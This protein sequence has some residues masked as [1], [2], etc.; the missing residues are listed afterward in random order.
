MAALMVNELKQ[1]DHLNLFSEALNNPPRDIAQIL[2]DILKHFG[3]THTIQEI[4]DLNNLLAWVLY[5]RR[6]LTLAE[7]NAAAGLESDHG[8]FLNIRDKI[9]SEFSAYFS[10][11]DIG[12]KPSN[13]N[14]KDITLDTLMNADQKDERLQA[15]Q[16]PENLEDSEEALLRLTHSSI[17][18]FFR[19]AAKVEI[20]SKGVALGVTADEAHTRLL[21]TC[22]KL[23]CIKEPIQAV[24]S[25]STSNKLLKYAANHFLD[26][27][28]ILQPSQMPIQEKAEIANYMLQVFH[29]DEVVERWLGSS[30]SLPM[31]YSMNEVDHIWALVSD[32]NLRQGFSPENRALITDTNISKAQKIL[33]AVAKYIA[34]KWLE[35]PDS[36]REP[37]EW[38]YSLSYLRQIVSVY[39]IIRN[40]SNYGFD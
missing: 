25:I 35:Y 29:D 9:E 20:N 28:V 15:L 30:K 34:R 6:P 31:W 12:R 14:P 39:P 17:T 19:S 26:H 2:Q 21:K 27:L 4:N 13:S 23:L 16:D 33:G 7:V 5:A 24:G 3:H 1:K 37:Y 11:N 32:E 36:K 8:P 40:S 22:L 10:V 38:F 18:R